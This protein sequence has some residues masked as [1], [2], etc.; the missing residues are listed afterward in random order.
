MCQKSLL[1]PLSFSD[2]RGFQSIFHCSVEVRRLPITRTK[3]EK[4]RKLRQI[5]SILGAPLVKP[6][7]P[8]LKNLDPTKN[9]SLG[10]YSTSTLNR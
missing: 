9:K 10:S 1:P 5:V 2:Y 4:M 3:E 8:V 7:N 6:Q